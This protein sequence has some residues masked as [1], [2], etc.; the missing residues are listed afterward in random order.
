MNNVFASI[1][2]E[3]KVTIESP[4]FWFVLSILVLLALA[5]GTSWFYES[6]KRKK[7]DDNENR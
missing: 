5:V 2:D 1:I 3:L 7:E 6:P 4:A